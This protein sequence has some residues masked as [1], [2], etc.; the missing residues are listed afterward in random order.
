M[1]ILTFTILAGQYIAKLNLNLLKPGFGPVSFTALDFRAFDGLGGQLGVFVTG[2][3]G[4]VKS[5]LG[6]VASTSPAS[7]AT[8]DGLINSTDLNN[9]S[10]S[11]WSGVPGYINGMTYYKVKYDVGP[12]ST[13]N[14]Y[15]LPTTDG[16]IQFEDFVIFAMSYG[17]S[18]SH[19][20]PKINAEPTAPVESAAWRTGNCR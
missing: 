5:Y 1:I 10:V 11:Y 12:T 4:E 18:T 13:N 3:N 2:N 9:W 7:I 8:G 19:I 15:G 17:L 16:K 20:Y 6:D 14:V